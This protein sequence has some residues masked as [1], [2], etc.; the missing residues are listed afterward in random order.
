LI[1]KVIVVRLD[2]RWGTAVNLPI[3]VIDKTIVIG[4]LDPFVND[5][6]RPCVHHIRPEDC[7]LIVE[8]SLTAN[9]AAGFREKYRDIV[10]FCHGLEVAV[11]R[12]VVCSSATPLV[13]IET[14][15]I[16]DL[17]GIVATGK[18]ILQHGS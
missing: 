13:R 14:E 9:I 5:A 2:W 6:S 4:L 11:S 17:V 16:D 7:S 18:V 10:T 8:C 1:G 15:E 12:G 3:G